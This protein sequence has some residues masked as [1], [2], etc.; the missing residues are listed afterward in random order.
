MSEV[1]QVGI[2]PRD[3]EVIEKKMN[4]KV[5]DQT[6]PAKKHLTLWGDEFFKFYNS[7]FQVSRVDF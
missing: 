5:R 7:V 3:L 1:D 2:Q 6:K 4:E